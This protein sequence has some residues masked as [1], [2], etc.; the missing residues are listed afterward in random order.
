MS[1]VVVYSRSL[2]VFLFDLPRWHVELGDVVPHSLLVSSD[3]CVNV[4]D[5]ETLDSHLSL[6][7]SSFN[8]EFG[9]LR[10]L[11]EDRACSSKLYHHHHVQGTYLT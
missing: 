5:I 4:L 9:I 11:Y 1:C 6:D 3:R 2:L 10:E 7:P 8:V